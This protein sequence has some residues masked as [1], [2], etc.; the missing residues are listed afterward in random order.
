MANVDQIRRAM[1]TQPFR[2][3]SVRL[4]DGTVYSIHHPDWL[5]IPPVRRPREITYYNVV[6]RDTDEYETHW[7]D[8]GLISEV[9]VPGQVG[10]APA[11]NDGDSTH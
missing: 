2:G 10:A 1:R 7:I 8:L 3:F 4:V 6:N 11:P 9:I 5:S